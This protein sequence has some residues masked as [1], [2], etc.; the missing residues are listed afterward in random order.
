MIAALLALHLITGPVPVVIYSVGAALFAVLMFSRRWRAW[1]PVA[2][3]VIVAGFFVGLIVCWI[4]GDLLNL[5]GVTLSFASRA[6]FAVAVAGLGLGIARGIFE[7]RR[8]TFV[9]SLGAVSLLLVGLIGLNADLGEFPNLGNAIGVGAYR[10]LAIPTTRAHATIAPAVTQVM[11]T[12]GRIGTVDIPGTVSHFSARPAIVY[13]PP[14]ALLPHPVA[15]PV[16]VMLSGQP[17]G[18]S[19]LF[20]KGQMQSTLDAYARAHH[21]L[22]PI[23]VDADQLGAPAYNPMCLDSPLGNAATYLTVD[24]PNWIKSHLTVRAGA[25]NWAIG[26]FSEGGTCAIQ[27][28]SSYPGIYGAIV[29]ISGEVAP[30]RG[31]VQ[32]TIAVAFHGSLAAY[33]AAIPANIQKAHGPYTS[34]YALFSIGGSDL[35]YGA[36]LTATERSSAAHGMQTQLFVSPGTAHDW[37]TVAYALNQSLPAIS[38]HW[39]L[40]G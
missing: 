14:A 40:N 39:G 9:G 10:Q 4:L 17:G 22:A 31:S 6:W 30:F 23:V 36:G 13:L 20:I 28:G 24:V 34:S 7:R 1:L 35:R 8:L 2:I 33:K 5:F 11:P 37:R 32:N 12:S 29:D 27:L 38:S 19:D 15:L 16:I 26:G 21:G 25:A 3:S 18:P